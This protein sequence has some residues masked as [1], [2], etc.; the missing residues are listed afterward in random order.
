MPR[1]RRP[2]LFKGQIWIEAGTGAE[3]LISGRLEGA[4]SIGSRV[5]FVRER[6]L[7]GAAYARVTHLSFTVPLLGRGELVITERPLGTQDNKEM[8]QLPSKQTS[9]LDKT[10]QPQ[11][12]LG[13]PD[14]SNVC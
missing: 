13:G 5:D 9:T 6:K 12:C 4:R 3:V 2:G 8:F 1:K 11:F 10:A 14:L 7:D